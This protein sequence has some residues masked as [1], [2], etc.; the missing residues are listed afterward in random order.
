[1]HVYCEELHYTGALGA[2]ACTTGTKPGR[3]ENVASYPGSFSKITKL[4]E[5]WEWDW[6][7]S[8]YDTLGYT[9]LTS[10]QY[11]YHSYNGTCK[12]IDAYVHMVRCGEDQ[13]PKAGKGS[14]G[15]THLSP[16]SLSPGAPWKWSQGKTCP[17]SA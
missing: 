13:H 5:A 14:Q 17:S 7:L 9:Y 12:W 15:K 10:V 2:F 6:L 16:C 4:G 8:V 3:T 1:M 11:T